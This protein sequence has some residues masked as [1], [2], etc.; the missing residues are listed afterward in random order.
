MNYFEK[1]QFLTGK[2]FNPRNAIFHKRDILLCFLS[3]FIGISIGFLAQALKA[4]INFVT[5]IFYFGNFSFD[6]AVPADHH[7]GYWAFFIPILGG[8]IIGMIAR[9][10]NP[11]VYGHGIPETMEKILI[12]D[13]LIQKRMIFLKPISAAI[14]VGTGGPFGEEGPIIATGATFGS[15]IGQFIKMNS[16]E[17]RVLLSSGVAGAV[18]AAFGSPI[19]GIFLAIELMLFEFK[20]RS[21]VPASLAVIAAEFIRMKFMG[22]TLAFPMPLVPLPSASLEVVCYFIIGLIIGLIA[23]GITHCVHFLEAGFEKLP[24]HWMWWPAIGGIGVGAVGVFEPRVL[25]AGY[26]T[27][28][29]ILNGNIVG[30]VAVSLFIL[31]FLAWLIGVSSRTTAGTL[32]PLFMIGSA[33]GVMLGGMVTH[34]IPFIHIDPKIAAMVGMAALFA[35]VTRS[36]L[37]SIFIT[38][39]S[40]HQFWASIPVVTGCVAAYIVSLFMMQHSMITHGLVKKG[41]LIPHEENRDEENTVKKIEGEKRSDK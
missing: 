40:T 24:V 17:R 3:I 15:T 2:T 9:F 28:T 14:S 33:L 34:F 12:N 27:I 11:S 20:P 25:G 1:M 35:G 18:S 41:I 26:G 39:E 21:L 29:S 13:S 36:F 4:V 31:K 22:D 37:G 30:S 38:L 23:V 16:Y 32:A 7:L 8:I 19:G 5:N 6:E 10:V